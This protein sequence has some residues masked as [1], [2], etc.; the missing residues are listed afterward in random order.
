MRLWTPASTGCCRACIC[1]PTTHR[2]E[3]FTAVVWQRLLQLCFW[4]NHVRDPVLRKF[5]F[6][7]FNC[8]FDT[9]LTQVTPLGLR[10]DLSHMQSQQGRPTAPVPMGP[11]L[12][13]GTHSLGPDSHGCLGDR[14]PLLF[15]TGKVHRHHP[16]KRPL[17]AGLLWPEDLPPIQQEVLPAHTAS[18]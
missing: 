10:F 15:L 8:H 9:C 1:K 5:S 3:S 12:P 7:S 14:T 17:R 2:C 13:A 11:D 18:L 6:L 4:D 16:V